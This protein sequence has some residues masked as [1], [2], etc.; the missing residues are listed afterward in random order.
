MCAERL[1]KF[2]LDHIKLQLNCLRFRAGIRF[3]KLPRL[4]TGGQPYPLNHVQDAYEIL[5][6]K[7]DSD[8]FKPKPVVKSVEERMLDEIDAFREG[9]LTDA[10]KT[11][12]AARRD[13]VVAEIERAKEERSQD[14]EQARIRRDTR[15][16]G[17]QGR[18]R[19]GRGRSRGRGRRSRTRTRVPARQ[20]DDM[21][22]KRVRVPSSYFGLSDGDVYGG[23]VGKW[24][25]YIGGDFNEYRGYNILY[26][27]GDQYCMI[28]SDVK[29]YIVADSID[30]VGITS[31]GT[32]P[33]K[34]SST[35]SSDDCGDDSQSDDGFSSDNM[36]I[37]EVLSEKFHI[38]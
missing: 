7:F 35:E 2:L 33:D 5:L 1:D 15:T 31:T 27:L 10:A 32:T 6:R 21:E 16:R 36:T 26:D 38:E 37:Q 34:S 3:G 28:E 8:T 12:Y 18:G 22:G 17:R 14:L 19:R 29:T 20:F 11:L 25:R 13:K 9:T 4:S 30:D 24:V 23:V